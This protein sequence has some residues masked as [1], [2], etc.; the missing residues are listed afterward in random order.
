MNV[1][2]KTKLNNHTTMSRSLKFALVGFT[3]V[4]VMATLSACDI[5]VRPFQEVMLTAPRYVLFEISSNELLP[6]QDGRLWR[7][8][9]SSYAPL[10][11][12]RR[13]IVANSWVRSAALRGPFVPD[14]FF[15]GSTGLRLAWDEC[16]EHELPESILG[17]TPVLSA[18]QD[19]LEFSWRPPGDFTDTAV[20]DELNRASLRKELRIPPATDSTGQRLSL[21]FP[22]AQLRFVSGPPVPYLPP[23]RWSDL[24]TPPYGEGTGFS[25]RT[26]ELRPGPV[27]GL[28]RPQVIA[29]YEQVSGVLLGDGE[30]SFWFKLEPSQN[31]QSVA[32]WF[33]PGTDTSSVTAYARCG[34]IPMHNLFDL[35][36]PSATGNTNTPIFLD[37][38]DGQCTNGWNVVIA[39]EPSAPVPDIVFHF[40]VAERFAHR[41]WSEIKVGIE[42]PTSGPDE[43]QAIRDALRW[44]AWKFYGMTGGTQIIRSFRYDPA[45]SCHKVHI[46]WRNRPAE[47]GCGQGSGVHNSISGSIHICSDP[48][49]AAP[50]TESYK[51]RLADNAST[52]AHEFGHKFAGLADEY[53][54]SNLVARICGE[55][56]FPDGA[57][58]LIKRCSHSAMSFGWSNRV[59]SLCVGHAHNGAPEFHIQTAPGMWNT[60]SFNVAGP[61]TISECWNGE[62]NRAGPYGSPAWSQMVGIVPQPHPN[63]TPINYNYID[64]AQSSA[65]TEI[66]RNLN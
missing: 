33:Q 3:F 29:P 50:T 38:P 17:C 65:R 61:N 9:Y 41:E 15:P 23:P 26:L 66:G 47:V 14:L 11:D 40:T 57:G 20:E 53:W 52:L 31:A 24:S 63:W 36:Q 1:F 7:G 32:I 19:R 21:A 4:V 55:P 58:R 30:D 25:I 10:L 60:R 49:P 5:H 8:G 34:A 39:S 27:R 42:K 56:A 54:K 35:S 22:G 44:A 28:R 43:E 48:L 16:Q 45:G 12:H 62:T 51:L 59:N 37:F 18:D 64:F 2:C 46:C 13:R 6:N